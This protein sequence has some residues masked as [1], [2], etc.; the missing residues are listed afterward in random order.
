MIDAG[1]TLL[2]D[3]RTDVGERHDLANVRQDIAR[4]LRPLLD[5]WEEDVEAEVQD[6]FGEV[7]T[8]D[9]SRP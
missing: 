4:Q 9:T 2:F 3:L 8:N 7:P 5:A 1:A 6:R